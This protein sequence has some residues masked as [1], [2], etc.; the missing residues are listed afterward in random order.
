MSGRAGPGGQREADGDR[1]GSKSDSEKG[2][3]VER[4][5]ISSFHSVSAGLRNIFLSFGG[6]KAIPSLEIGRCLLVGSG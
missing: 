3:K 6:K 2:K 5:H 1:Q 4:R